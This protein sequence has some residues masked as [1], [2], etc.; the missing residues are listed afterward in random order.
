MVTTMRNVLFSVLALLA[1]FVST[2]AKAATE[3]VDGYT[4]T[5]EV[6]G[7]SVSVEGISPKPTG[8]L[9]IPST[10]GGKP[11]T[12]IGSFAFEECESLTSVTI[13]EGVTSIV[14]YA[15]S[16]CRSLTSVTIPSRVTCIVD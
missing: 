13:S 1:V 10:L 6:S 15:F 7:D 9:T 8:S 5:Y 2:V 14:W 12:E 4:W 3:T 16:G 11:V